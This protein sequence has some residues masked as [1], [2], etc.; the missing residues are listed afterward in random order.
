MIDVKH[1]NGCRDDYYNQAVPGG[2]WLREQAQ[3][4]M[5]RRV[6]INDVPPWRKKPEELP[7]CYR[8]SGFV[9]F[10]PDQES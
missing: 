2:C 6:H 7:S 10:K 8:Q 9:F 5:R 1:C 4:L 3:L